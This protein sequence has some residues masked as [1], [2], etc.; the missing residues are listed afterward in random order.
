MDREVFYNK[1]HIFFITAIFYI[2]IGFAL[3]M[4]V[5]KFLVT[6]KYRF[7]FYAI[8]FILLISGF[9]IRVSITGF[10][11]VTNMYGTMLWVSF[12]ITFFS[13]IILKLYERPE[14][15]GS[16]WI[17]AAG[18]LLTA[19]SIPLILSPDLDP[20][21]A[22]LRSNLWLT[23][24]VLTIVISYAAFANAMI[25]GNIVLVRTLIHGDYHGQ[26]VKD[27]AMSCYRMIQL[28]C[29]LI[30]VGIILGGVWADY[31]WGRFW[32]WDPKE[33]WA[34]I[35][36][37]GF[38]A[39]LHAKYVG[40]LSAFGILASST[41]AFLLVLMAWYGVNFILAAGLHSYGF[42]SGGATIVGT[43]VSIQLIVLITALVVRAQREKNKGVVSK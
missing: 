20:I 11:P 30:T 25:L 36:D 18:F 10:A 7:I 26:M 17:A 8:P 42:S 38:L 40:W 27:F 13:L 14:V 31:S 4:G 16:L 9:I 23:I 21:V 37:L 35:A 24:H 34:L 39:V 3:I 41:V 22:V 5:P 33:T 28:G 43:F 2:L 29:F 12:G 15:V 6:G 1:S 32:G 19:E